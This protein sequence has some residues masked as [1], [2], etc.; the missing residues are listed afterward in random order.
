MECKCQCVQCS[1]SWAITHKSKDLNKHLFCWLFE[2]LMSDVNEYACVCISLTFLHTQPRRTI[3][4]WRFLNTW[5]DLEREIVKFNASK[6]KERSSSFAMPIVSD[7]I[8]TTIRPMVDSVIE[9]HGEP[10]M[11]IECRVAKYLLFPLRISVR[12]ERLIKKKV[13]NVTKSTD[14]SA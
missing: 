4:R 13:Q 11:G 3:P 6:C 14:V 1:L 10:L 7:L 9:F 12:H 8:L 5:F 2:C